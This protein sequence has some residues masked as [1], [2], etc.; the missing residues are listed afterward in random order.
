M[1]SEEHGIKRP[2][3]VR[4]FGPA[5]AV[6]IGSITLVVGATELLI[7]FRKIHIFHGGIT[8]SVFG[9]LLL[10]SAFLSKGSGRFRRSAVITRNCLVGIWLVALALAYLGSFLLSPFQ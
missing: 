3:T 10:L 5:S 8:T 4:S 7:N 6:W 1:A 2:E 9:T